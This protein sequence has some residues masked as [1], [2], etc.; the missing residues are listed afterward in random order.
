MA[1]NCITACN[2]STSSSAGGTVA[3]SLAQAEGSQSQDAA[4]AAGINNQVP[5]ALTAGAGKAGS[6]AAKAEDV[7]NIIMEELKEALRE[8]GFGDDGANENKMDDV[9]ATIEDKFFL[10]AERLHGLDITDKERED[11]EGLVKWDL[12]KKYEEALKS[13]K[14]NAPLTLREITEIVN[15]SVTRIIINGERLDDIANEEH[16]V[17]VASRAASFAETS[18]TATTSVSR[19]ALSTMH[20]DTMAVAQICTVAFIAGLAF[21]WCRRR[22]RRESRVLLTHTTGFS[23]YDSTAQHYD[24]ERC[25]AAYPDGYIC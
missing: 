15:R 13:Q 4:S 2:P 6:A 9:I 1:I 22:S 5:A 19:V 25:D 10:E 16:P 8:L 20:F 12:A 21:G 17:P 18:M 23:K 24:L 3:N 7:K 11:V 14:T